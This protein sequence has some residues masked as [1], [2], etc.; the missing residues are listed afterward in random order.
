MNRLCRYHGIMALWLALITGLLLLY[1][2]SAPAAQPAKSA[3][4]I[5]QAQVQVLDNLIQ[6][7]GIDLKYFAVHGF[8]ASHEQLQASQEYLIEMA[9]RYPDDADYYSALGEVTYRI[10]RQ[11]DGSYSPYTLEDAL[12]VIDKALQL[13]PSH[14]R[15]NILKAYIYQAQGRFAEAKAT[16]HLVEQLMPES[17]QTKLLR[18][19]LD[20]QRD[21]ARV[22]PQLKEVDNTWLLNETR[23]RTYSMLVQAYRATGEYA[24]AMDTLFQL[25][26][27]EPESPWNKLDYAW[28]IQE[29]TRFEEAMLW[30]LQVKE[31]AD[32][33]KTRQLLA[34]AYLLIGLKR[35]NNENDFDSGI[36]FIASAV[37]E[38]PSIFTPIILS[39]ILTLALVA[40]GCLFAFVA[41]K[42]WKKYRQERMTVTVSVELPVSVGQPTAEESI[43]AAGSE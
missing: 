15:A 11:P 13:A 4:A 1:P 8:R 23:I 39:T 12:Q 26:R 36:A 35:W 22:I 34:S 43:P 7:S 28:A 41:F 32:Y 10:A 31:E 3:K 37:K 21:P 33:D 42:A 6:S 30:L 38:D 24:L 27:M 14:V 16:C 20:V 19:A 17:S 40:L 2:A 9:Q 29:Q 25:K 5:S 18:A